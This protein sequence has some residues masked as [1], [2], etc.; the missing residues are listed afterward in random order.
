MS[1]L[2][3]IKDE[4]EQARPPSRH[5]PMIAAYVQ[6]VTVRSNRELVEACGSLQSDGSQ[7]DDDAT[8]VAHGR[9]H[10]GQMY[11]QYRAV[12]MSLGVTVLHNVRSLSWCDAY[13]V[14]EAFMDQVVTLADSTSQT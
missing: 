5:L 6:R 14:D 3:K 7:G 13:A 4:A 8:D 1:L 12:I 11:Q 2:M 9:H 10:Y